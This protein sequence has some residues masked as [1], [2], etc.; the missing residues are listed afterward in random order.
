MPVIIHVFAYVSFYS[1][2]LHYTSDLDIVFISYNCGYNA[3]YLL[4][5]TVMQKRS[6][7]VRISTWFSVRHTVCSSSLQK[8][9]LPL[10]S[11]HLRMHNINIRK[12][13]GKMTNMAPA[14]RLNTF[15][16]FKNHTHYSTSFKCKSNHDI[17]LKC[18]R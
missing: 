5:C 18:S 12:L 14:G 3:F 9:K 4:Y 11:L 16:I 17:H 6:F 13:L 15:F 7:L 8:C 1:A 2:S 10:C